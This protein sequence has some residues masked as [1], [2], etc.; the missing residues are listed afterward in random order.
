MVQIN[1]GGGFLVNGV[2]GAQH[3]HSHAVWV[4]FGAVNGIGLRGVHMEDPI[5]DGNSS[6]FF[7]CGQGAAAA[8]T[9][10]VSRL[11]D[12]A[13]CVFNVAVPV[14]TFLNS[15]VAVIRCAGSLTTAYR[16]VIV[17]DI[18]H[19]YFGIAHLGLHHLLGAAGEQEQGEYQEEKE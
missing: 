15:A 9:A 16:V 1:N 19:Y 18:E 10:L 14:F 8:D 13:G 11:L 7:I 17:A 4:V 12:D 6:Q 2:I 5:A 3:A